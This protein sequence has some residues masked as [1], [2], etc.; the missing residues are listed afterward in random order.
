MERDR[1]FEVIFEDESLLVVHKPADLVCHPTKGDIYSSL[2]S[3][4][5]LYLPSEATSA[6]MINRLDRETS[7]LVLIAKDKETA[8]LLARQ[9]E[10]RSVFKTYRALVLEWPERDTLEIHASLGKDLRSAVYVKDAVCEY[11]TPAS[12][13]VK[14]LKRFK[15]QGKPYSLLEVYPLTGRKHQIRIHL[16]SIGHSIVG[17]KLYGLDERYYLALVNGT[18]AD[19][20]RANL[21]LPY[22]ALHAQSVSIDLNGERRTFTAREEAWFEAFHAAYPDLSHREDVL[23]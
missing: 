17:D 20:D 2:I 11:V 12:T 16:Q 6:H 3:R 5:R 14:V 18:L 4:V 8:R 21:L 15:R 1:L 9:W 10:S 13:H 23:I 19:E 22:Q 7:G